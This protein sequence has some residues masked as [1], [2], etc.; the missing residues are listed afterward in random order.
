MFSNFSFQKPKGVAHLK[1]VKN[2]EGGFFYS[3]MPQG[4]Y[5][6]NSFYI[7]TKMEFEVNYR[8]I[9]PNSG[10][11]PKKKINY[12][13]TESYKRWTYKFDFSNLANF[14]LALFLLV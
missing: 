10:G 6:N 12:V 4:I 14:L 11:I 5:L 9:S 1:N 3:Y 13:I 2:A 7:R 8:L